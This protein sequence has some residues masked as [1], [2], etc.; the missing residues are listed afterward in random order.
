MHEFGTLSKIWTTLFEAQVSK[1]P[2]AVA[3]IRGSSRVSFEEL[4]AMSNKLA[5]ALIDRG[6][7]P[8]SV[9]AIAIPRSVEMIVAVI[10]VAK[11]GGAYLPVASSAPR[12]RARFMI[13]NGGASL[14]LATRER[15]ASIDVNVPVK[16]LDDHQ[17]A[18]EVDQKDASRPTDR[19]RTAMLTPEHPAYILY[20]SGSTGQPKGVCVPHSALMSYIA[21]AGPY[22][23]AGRGDGAPLIMP[24]S[25]DGSVTSLHVPLLCGRPVILLPEEGALEALA[26]ILVSG[27]DLTLVHLTPSHLE[28]LRLILG[29]RI[30]NVR[31]RS[32]VSIGEALSWREASFWTR[33]CPSVRLIN[34]Y[35]PTEATVAVTAYTVGEADGDDLKATVPIGRAMPGNDLY[36]LDGS[37]RPV[38]PGEV[39]EIFIGGDQVANGYVNRADLTAERFLDCPFGRPGGRMYRTG[40]L[41]FHRP[42]GNLAYCGRA[43]RQIK[44]RGYRIEPAEIEAVLAKISGVRQVAVVPRAFEGET[45]LVGYVVY[46]PS[47]RLSAHDLLEKA[48]KT[49]PD[50]MLPSAIVALDS[51]PLTVSGKLD[52][53]ALP[54]PV[55]IGTA[56]VRPPLSDVEKQLAGLFEKL[57]GAR[58]V[59]LDDDFF[60]IGGDSLLGIRLMLEIEDRFCLKMPL[61]TLFKA[62]TVGR[63]A[64]CLAAGK[65]TVDSWSVIPLHTAG[66]GTPIFMVHWI[67]RDLARHLGATH[68]VYGLSYGLAEDPPEGHSMPAS[69]E[70]IASHYID[71]MRTIQESGPYILVGH[72]HGGLIA[73]E[74]AVQLAEQ[75]DPA[76]FLALLDSDVPTLAARS[77][78]HVSEWG[79]LF[80]VRR[81]AHS[82][83]FR[84]KKLLARHPAISTMFGVALEGHLEPPPIKRL[85]QVY[86]TA[87]TYHPRRYSGKL[88]LLESMEEEIYPSKA[89]KRRTWSE[90]AQAGLVVHEISGSHLGIVK[91][92]VARRTAEVILTALRADQECSKEGTDL[93]NSRSAEHLL[94]LSLS[95]QRAG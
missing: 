75:E 11:A 65:A 80:D 79:A 84:V 91:N 64:Q 49:L 7:G 20:T 29:P 12:D 73:Y 94:A 28:G 47:N 38:Q 95:V 40:D 35:G 55:V 69:I 41:G 87:R 60:E 5:H 46:D 44:I 30:A 86:V 13:T 70:D 3:L 74:M 31:A 76:E 54:D 67:E 83:S 2:K 10:A 6:I 27:L 17:F 15:A 14:V 23:E 8:N 90:L 4:D 71:Q 33:N 42:D 62:P 24:L 34:Q 1:T 45:R 61:G 57:T 56:A 16:C 89:S 88:H 37:L 78:R 68:P 50:Y 21:W 43:D 92:P 59:G 51:I 25:F 19:V 72:S 93:T 58:N 9:V 22:F 48:S 36:V 82:A 63:L 52:A 26:D 85:R 53:S 32:F 77:K 39:G 81:L 18:H 66:A